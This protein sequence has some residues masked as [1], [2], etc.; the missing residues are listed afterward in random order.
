MQLDRIRCQLIQIKIKW[1]KMFKLQN[2]NEFFL[3]TT[4]VTAYQVEVIGLMAS[5][6][7]GDLLGWVFYSRIQLDTTCSRATC[8]RCKRRISL[9]PHFTVSRKMSVDSSSTLNES[10]VISFYLQVSSTMIVIL[11]SMLLCLHQSR[12]G[13]MDNDFISSCSSKLLDWTQYKYS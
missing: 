11:D 9:R 5:V 12:H 13:L 2:N 6:G 4:E 8:I 10:F 3:G 7:L 1:K